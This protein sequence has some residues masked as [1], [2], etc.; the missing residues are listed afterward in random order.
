MARNDTDTHKKANAVF[1]SFIMIASM[2]AI[3]FAGFA[4]T[5]AAEEDIGDFQDQLT[6]AGAGTAYQVVVEDITSEAAQSVVIIDT[7]DDDQVVGVEGADD[8]D[9]K[10][11]GVTVEASLGSVAD[12]ADA[13]TDSLEAYV[14]DDDSTDVDVGSDALGDVEERTAGVGADIFST[15]GIAVAEQGSEATEF[16]LDITSPDIDSGAGQV[17]DDDEY[18]IVVHEG[19][20]PAGPVLATSDAADADGSSIGHVDDVPLNVGDNDLNVVVHEDSDGPPIPLAGVGDVADFGDATAAGATDVDDATVGLQQFENL[21][22]APT[23]SDADTLV[24][25]DITVGTPDDTTEDPNITNLEA[26]VIEIPGANV[27]G[28]SLE[29]ISS[30]GAGGGIDGGFDETD[31]TDED[32]ADDVITLTV[33]PAGDDIADAED[34]V[35]VFEDITN[36]NQDDVD[37][38]FDATI[39][40]DNQ[41]TL[42]DTQAFVGAALGPPDS[43]YVDVTG[44]DAEAVFQG[45]DTFLIGEDLGDEGDDVDLRS[46]D[47]FDD[48]VVGSNSQ[49]EQLEVEAVSELDLVDGA[50]TANDLAVEIETD[51]LDA[52]DHFVRGSGDL[53]TRPA[54]EDTFQVTIQDL[55]V[56]FDDAE[57]TD[58]GPDSVTDLDF[59]SNRGTY[60]INASANGDLDE[61]ELLEAFIN[62]PDADNSELLVAVHH[63][64]SE[65][66]VFD[67]ADR[68]AI[69]TSAGDTPDTSAFD[70]VDDDLETLLDDELDGLNTD[71]EF[72]IDE[73]D[74]ATFLN[75]V[76]FE[77]IANPAGSSGGT[78]DFTSSPINDAALD[79]FL[80]NIEEDDDGNELNPFRA[81]TFNA[82]EDGADE[83]V[84]MIQLRDREENVDFT[85]VEDDTYEFE[86]N[87]SDTGVADTGTIEILEEDQ[88]G[89][90]VPSV[91][92]AGAGDIVAFEL[93]L[94]DT[95]EAFIQIGDEDAGYVD[96]ILIEDDG[97]PDDAVAFQMNTRVAG[98][99]ADID[100]VYDSENDEIHA[101]AVHSAAGFDD[102]DDAA[103]DDADY[104]GPIFVDDDDDVLTGGTNQFTVYLE[105]L[106]LIDDED[107]EDGQDQ[108]TRPLQPVNYGVTAGVNDATDGVFQAND[109]RSSAQ[110]ELDSA[111]M[112]LTTP[113]IGQVI[114]HVAP[115][116][117]A[118]EDDE[119]DDLLTSVTPREDVAIDDRLVVQIEATGLY[120][121]ML[122]LDDDGPDFDILED[123]TSGNVIHQI[124]EEDDDVRFGGGENKDITG[125]GINIDVEAQDATGNQDPTA[126]LFDGAVEDEVFVVIGEEQEQF[127]IIVDTNEDDA[128]ENGAPDDGDI[129]DAT[130]EYET[131]DDRYEFDDGDAFSGGAD[132]DNE[133]AAYPFLD[134]DSDITVRTSFTFEDAAAD[135]DNLTEDGDVQVVPEEGAEVSGE[136]NVAPG[137]SASV[138][139]RSTGDT[140]PSFLEAD[141]ADIEGDGAFAATFDLSGQAEG[142]TADAI[143]RADSDRIDTHGA[144]FVDTIE[145]VEDTPTPTPEEVEGEDTPTP[146]EVEGEDTPTPT[147]TPTPEDTVDD[148]PGFG[149]AVALVALIIAALLATRRRP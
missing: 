93:E 79:D 136:T 96:V 97:E 115:A 60:S 31:V 90:F 9:E 135:F 71:E 80:D 38:T 37:V 81:F 77:G 47:D 24:D 149:A 16:D 13:P 110:D 61:E 19:T 25:Y 84:V 52:E 10:N 73:A 87:V 103:S 119:V 17:G 98:T 23:D 121:A 57:V 8:L 53:P 141:D 101:S 29:E 113:D 39:D 78:L 91:T 127:F 5:A 40:G 56:A 85:G 35:F 138:R 70:R 143:F 34:V 147:P 100:D 22:V 46:V 144:V 45:Q 108:L 18:H 125:E 94:D 134:A 104:D 140:S 14:V 3:G 131:D 58:G 88:D 48:G 68:P 137:T 7:D 118:D 54:E 49:V 11:V 65:A 86:F 99:N 75:D 20:G 111:Q 41:D 132:E 95:D 74:A 27:N 76:V 105:A 62:S 63:G 26:V 2:S 109:G 142:D 42:T 145:E 6:D 83:T 106:D 72:G 129:F 146:E 36:P 114:T 128:F 117:S 124:T 30:D 55:D 92:Q 21:D 112:V 43:D 102:L 28:A 64:I 120:G 67:A 51:D 15:N 133:E 66:V 82:E 44:D 59:D 123:G 148:A 139:L 32:F 122:A 130:V 116:D 50:A 12:S 126:V 107:T 33:D 4:G 89:T 1:F 69:V